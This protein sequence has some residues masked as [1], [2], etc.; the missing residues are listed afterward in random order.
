[1]PDRLR[2]YLFGQQKL[3]ELLEVLRFERSGAAE[4]PVAMRGGGQTR[5]YARYPFLGD[6]V[7]SIPADMYDI[8]GEMTLEASVDSVGWRGRKLRITGHAYIHRVS[9]ADLSDCRIRVALRG[10]RNGRTIRL[11]V[12]PLARP[13]VTA[14][15][16]QAAISYDWSGFAVEVPLRRLARPGRR[17]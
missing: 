6:P 11:P 4:A 14:P 10:S 16:G 17:W 7:H 9:S 8:T 15:S 2:G 5:W 1:M 13:S 3:P 12:S